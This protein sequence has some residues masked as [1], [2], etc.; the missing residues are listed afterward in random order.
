MCLGVGVVGGGGGWGDC[1]ALHG[2]TVKCDLPGNCVTENALLDSA[3]CGCLLLLESYHS[4][5]YSQHD[6][7]QKVLLL[8]W[9]LYDSTL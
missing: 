4:S 7:R 9:L 3:Y 8:L 6:V 5:C 2:Q 1:T